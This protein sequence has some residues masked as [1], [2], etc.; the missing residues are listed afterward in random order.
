MGGKA[1][2]QRKRLAIFQKELWVGG[3]QKSLLNLIENLD[4]QTYEIDL[5]LFD[6]EIFYDVSFPENVT[7][8][9]C[10][11]FPFFARFLYFPLVYRLKKSQFRSEK[12][13]DTAIDFNSY[14]PECAVGALSVSAD[15]RIMWVH[16][17]VRQVRRQERKYRLLWHFFKGKFRRFDAFAAVSRGAAEAFCDEA[18]IGDRP[19]TPIPNYIDTSEIFRKAEAEIAFSPDPQKV[20]LCTMGRM[21]Y[22][23]GFDLLLE[24]FA[25]AHALR[26]ELHLYFIGDGELRPALQQQ[27]ESLGL[28]DA[29]T[30]L[31]YQSDPFPYLEKMDGFVLTSRYEGQGMVLWEA[32]ALGLPVIIPKRLEAYND[33]IDGVEDVAEALR[34]FQKT[35][36]HRDA[37]EAYNQTITERLKTLL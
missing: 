5:F 25:R 32:K 14:Q 30:M 18:K 15:K 33:G 21:C 6:R 29:V 9:F 34:Q 11:P 37:L 26:P 36:K 13:Y 7:V 16:N 2:A 22:Q 35:E 19:V 31:G 24:D 1:V 20:N 23:K 10:K 17:D 8:H 3:I 27:I 12:H 28:A 4:R